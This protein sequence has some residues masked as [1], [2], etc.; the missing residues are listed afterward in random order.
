MLWLLFFLFQ[1]IA[2]NM[3]LRKPPEQI[4]LEYSILKKFSKRKKHEIRFAVLK[5]K[6][7]LVLVN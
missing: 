4:N 2:S 5:I 3:T 7:L 1:P 6:I